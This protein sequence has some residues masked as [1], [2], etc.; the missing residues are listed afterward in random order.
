ME[1]ENRV[2]EVNNIYSI[3]TVHCMLT[4]YILAIELSPYLKDIL[5][6]RNLR[7]NLFLGL[8]LIRSDNFDHNYDN[9]CIAAS[10]CTLIRRFEAFYLVFTL[11]FRL[12]KDLTSVQLVQIL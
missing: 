5:R 6:M 3:Q 8:Y 11:F 4:F 10:S 2:G 9:F 7:V 12:A 1:V